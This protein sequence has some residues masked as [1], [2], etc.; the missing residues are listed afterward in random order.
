MRKLFEENNEYWI[1]NIDEIKKCLFMVS[2]EED[3]ETLTQ[4]SKVKLISKNFLNFTNEYIFMKL[5]ESIK[6]ELKNAKKSFSNRT[7]NKKK[8]SHS[9]KKIHQKSGNKSLNKGFN[10]KIKKCNEKQ[11]EVTEIA[12]NNRIQNGS[13]NS[14]NPISTPVITHVIEAN[15][16]STDIAINDN[17]IKATNNKIEKNDEN[18]IKNIEQTEKYFVENNITDILKLDIP[19]TSNFENNYLNVEQKVFYLSNS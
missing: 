4:N 18:A 2:V 1:P 5:N 10:K 3:S 9:I 7:D 14:A 12:S 13:D 6:K 19:S 16:M 8:L 17:E 11:F 15:V